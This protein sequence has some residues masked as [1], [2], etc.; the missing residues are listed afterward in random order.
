MSALELEEERRSQYAL[1]TELSEL[2]S[3][4][5]EN[6]LEMNRTV[7]QQNKVQPST[8]RYMAYECINF[9]S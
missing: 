6:T 1:V 7:L 9:L 2:T 5:K 4:L 3:V 8:A